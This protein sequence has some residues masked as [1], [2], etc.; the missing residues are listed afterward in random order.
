MTPPRVLFVGRATFDVAYSL[1]QFP[2]EDTKVFARAMRFAPGGPATNAAIT[3]ALLGGQAVL[4]TAV[5]SGAW[6]APVR[7][8]L[9]RLG[10]DLI[11]LA[12]GTCYEFPFTTVLVNE[13]GA[14]RT[15]VNPPQSELELKRIEAWDPA[16]GEAP[17]LVLTDG[18]H[19]NETMPLL[20]ACRA[21]GAQLCLD[22][23]SRKPG[24]EELASLLSVAICSERF[25][26]AQG[27]ADP[28]ESMEWLAEQG[29]SRIA[30][31]HGARP[32]LGWDEGRKFEIEIA[33]I[34]AVDT[35]GAGDVLHGAFCYYFSEMG[36]FEPALRLAADI[37]TRSC[38]QL[39]IRGWVTTR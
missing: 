4:M 22:G 14:T 28:G 3:H 35:L 11:D 32:I 13:A 29:V 7:E 39:G 27:G 12:G 24:T 5:G 37:A 15:V 8:E 19:L 6:A 25:R 9:T 21:E 20:R 17:R 34:D 26:I 23:G 16:W 1:D 2:A 38:C 33:A 36:E 10:I 18:F 30:I 31:T